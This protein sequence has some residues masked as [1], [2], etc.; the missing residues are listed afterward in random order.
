M[1]TPTVLVVLDGFGYSPS[2]QDNAIA[3]AR[4]PN[5]DR[6]WN[7]K[8]HALISGSGADVGL[9]DDQMGNSEVG[10]MNIG[11]GRKDLPSL[12]IEAAE[13]AAALASA[14]ASAIL[15]RTRSPSVLTTESWCTMPSSAWVRSRG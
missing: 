5:W 4:T 15:A 1:K 11:A 6:F 7:E 9:P 13:P 3:Q 10:H 14:A 8:P 12:D 2:T